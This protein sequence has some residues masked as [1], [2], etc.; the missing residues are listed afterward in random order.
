MRL[1]SI[2]F[3][4]ACGLH[5]AFLQ[6]SYFFLL[7]AYLSS[8]TLS[9]FVVLFF[10]L[11][12]FLLGLNVRRQGWFA[13]LLVLGVLTY[14]LTW[15]LTQVLPFHALLYAVAGGCAV[16]SGLLPGYF[17]PY[18][19][20]RGQPV[21]SFLFHENNGFI[22]GVLLSLKGSIYCGVWFLALAPLVGGAL[23]LLSL[24]LAGRE[25]RLSTQET[26]AAHIGPGM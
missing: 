23:V 24:A 19:E 12:G 1:A 5:F 22:V 26:A 4:Y 18:M 25:V 7:E 3:A 13:A 10:W 14:Y 11:C 16:L 6:F 9:F 17:F 20:Q 8:Q 15:G 2:V 21:K